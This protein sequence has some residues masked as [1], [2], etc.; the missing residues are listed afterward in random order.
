MS[1]QFWNSTD[2]NCLSL[3][4]ADCLCLD[5]AMVQFRCGHVGIG[6]EKISHSYDSNSRQV[7]GSTRAD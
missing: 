4:F 1:S 6:I 3:P 7:L 5:S 2:Q